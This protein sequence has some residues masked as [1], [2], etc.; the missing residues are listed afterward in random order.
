MKKNNG[1]FLNYCR[2]KSA[3]EASDETEMCFNLHRT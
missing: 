3:L 1:L 2:I